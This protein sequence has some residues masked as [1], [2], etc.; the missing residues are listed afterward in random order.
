M[1]TLKNFVLKSFTVCLLLLFYM[2]NLLASPAYPSLI[3]VEQPNGEVLDTYLKGDET[4]SYRITED[5]YV[6]V[7]N[8][9]DYFVYADQFIDSEIPVPSEI[10][11]HNQESRI[12]EEMV[13]LSE[14]PKGL[15]AKQLDYKLL[16]SNHS[17]GRST[18]VDLGSAGLSK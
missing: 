4:F 8:D 1:I 2:S 17:S 5:G 9:E 6:I 3:R 18:G 10:V 14:M 15:T 7:K 12:G 13:F 11:A 16:I